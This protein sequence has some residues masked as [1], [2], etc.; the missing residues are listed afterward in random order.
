MSCNSVA[1]NVGYELNLV[2]PITH[3]MKLRHIGT[4]IVTHW[5]RKAKE[6]GEAIV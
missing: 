1:F 4:N 6:C 2:R 3:A 5:D